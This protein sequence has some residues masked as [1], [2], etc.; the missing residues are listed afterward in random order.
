MQRKHDARRRKEIY[1]RYRF[2]PFDQAKSQLAADLQQE[3]YR[4]VLDDSLKNVQSR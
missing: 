4:K 1:S 3:R 2:G